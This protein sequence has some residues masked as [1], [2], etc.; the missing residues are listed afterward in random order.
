MRRSPK[1]T[2]LL[3]CSAT[4]SAA[5]SLIVSGPRSLAKAR[6]VEPTSIPVELAARRRL[7]M[8]LSSPSAKPG[9]PSAS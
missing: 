6:V 7:A 5:S 9:G 4:D 8:M 3:L 1:T 2:E